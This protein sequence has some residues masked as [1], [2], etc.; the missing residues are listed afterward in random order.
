M[1]MLG[2]WAMGLVLAAGCGAGRE[3]PT[4]EELAAAD[5][6]ARETRALRD[7]IRSLG[8]RIDR[9]LAGI[10]QRI[11]A[12]EP[13]P[14]VLAASRAGAVETG[15]IEAGV[16]AAVERTVDAKLEQWAARTRDVGADGKWKPPLDALAAE[17]AL[18]EAQEAE[19][20][21]VFDAAKD[22]VYDV[23]RTMRLDGGSLLDDFVA[24]LRAGAEPQ[25]A[26]REL[27]QRIVNERVPGSDATY[28]GELVVITEETERAL[29][30]HLDA[31]QIEKIR[32][33]HVD[34]LD[35]K[36]GHDPVGDYVRAR[37]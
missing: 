8:D 27:F 23:L 15:A 2:L 6:T 17:L 31:A 29:A 28:L 22:Q 21:R 12:A 30:K 25:A 32:T 24:A 34:L 20:A 35:V 1:R 19:A 37:L 5:A 16:T 36:T 9:R 4:A 13:M 10:E 7:E 18:T 11:D 33:L 26:F 3:G 14:T